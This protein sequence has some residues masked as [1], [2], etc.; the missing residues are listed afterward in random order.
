MDSNRRHELETNDLK[1][2]FDN[3]KDFWEKHGNKL[4]IVLIVALLAYAG[5]RYYDN[6]QKGKAN[7]AAEAINS[8]T[9]PEALLAVADEHPMVRDEATRRAADLFFATA[10]DAKI[11]DDADTAEKALKDAASAYTA[12]AQRG[13]SPVYQIT[14]YKGLAK[15]AQEQGDVEQATAHYEKVI[16]LA[17]DTYTLF[18]A[19]AEQ[20]IENLPAVTNPVAF[21]PPRPATIDP[22]PPGSGSGGGDAGSAGDGFGPVLPGLDLPDTNPAAPGVPPAEEGLGQPDEQ[23]VPAE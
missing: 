5:P 3:F 13:E 15:V 1:D 17:G 4:L 20:A 23:P 22:T 2:F 16:E 14:G 10:R 18:A 21:S 9:T 7:D 19:R 12:I 11:Q 6:W 8:A